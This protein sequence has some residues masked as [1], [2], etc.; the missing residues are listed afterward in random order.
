VLISPWL[1]TR[2]MILPTLA[3]A[4]WILGCDSTTEPTDDDLPAPA[5]FEVEAPDEA[6]AGESFE[7]TLRA[8]DEAGG[9]LE[10]YSGSVTLSPSA[11]RLTTGSVEVQGG[12]GS[13]ATSIEDVLGRVTLAARVGDAGGTSPAIDVVLRE[14]PGDPDDPATASIP[15]L[16]PVPDPA[17]FTLDAPELEGF[18]VSFRTLIVR[19]ATDVTVADLNAD[20]VALGARILGGAPDAGGSSGVLVLGFDSASPEEL[21][22]I[23]DELAGHAWALGL[24]RDTALATKLEPSTSGSPDS[25][26]AWDATPQGGNW[27][28]ELIRAPQMWN[29]N[30][31]VFKTGRRIRVGVIDVGFEPNHPDLTYHT[32]IGSDVYDHGTHVAGTI[33][34]TWNGDGVNGLCPYAD[35][36]AM[37]TIALGSPGGSDVDVNAAFGSMFISLLKLMIGGIP[38]VRVVNMSLGYPRLLD[39]S[40]SWAMQYLANEQG[41][42]LAETLRDQPGLGRA[43][44]VAAA[45]N[46][47]DEGYGDQEARYASPMA[48]AAIAQG[49]DQIIVVESVR[50]T[51]GV[52]GDATRASSSNI[53][54]QVSAPGVD[55]RSTWTGP[56]LYEYSSGTSMATPHVT[57]LAAYALALDPDL[58]HAQLREILTLHALPVAGGASRRIDA[59]RT[60]LEIDRVRGNDRVLELLVDIDDGTSDGNLRVHPVTGDLFDSEDADGD[61]GIG[62]GVVDMSDFR[63]YRDWVHQLAVTDGLSFDG[64]LIHAKHDIDGNGQVETDA[65][66]AVY[67]RGDFNGDGS[68][69]PEATAFVGGNL[70][71]GVTDLA[72]L[73]YAFHDPFYDEEELPAL[74]SSGDVVIDATVLFDMPGVTDVRTEVLRA[75]GTLVEERPLAEGATANV[76]TLALDPGGYD[77]VTSAYDDDENLVAIVDEFANPRLCEDL[78]RKLEIEPYYIVTI[79]AP[80]SAEPGVE[81]VFTARVGIRQPDGT[82]DFPAGTAVSVAADDGTASL[83]SDVTNVDGLVAGRATMLESAT[84]MNLHITASGGALDDET[85]TVAV[86]AG[87][88]LLFRLRGGEVETDVRAEANA[89]TGF[90]EYD[91]ETEPITDFGSL[92]RSASA[93]ISADSVC[94]WGGIASGYGEA[95]SSIEADLT[96]DEATRTLRFTGTGQSAISGNGS[97]DGQ[98]SA[99]GGGA[100]SADYVIEFELGTEDDFDRDAGYRYHVEATMNAAGS[101]LFSRGSG[102]VMLRGEGVNVV[103]GASVNVGDDD[104]SLT[105]SATLDETGILGPGRYTFRVSTTSS[106]GASAP[107][108]PEVSGSGDFTVELTLSPE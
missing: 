64:G 100:A 32:R 17:D 104:G 97:L 53:G 60:V 28:M 106:G 6:S 4:G 70:Q 54:G 41:E 79:Y 87:D 103:A 36:V 58:T 86:S 21:D 3:V 90:Y 73:A 12:V 15:L 10:H 105:D 51:P 7:V 19:V 52:V 18:P 38:D 9:V 78:Y 45:G 20:L 72:V 76:F 34:A 56:K 83:D 40:S 55:I 92:A 101:G 11:G 81:F 30:D 80:E 71:K 63:R 44:I 2:W 88:L 25:T 27:G 49:L 62:D 67:P 29:L 24:A 96:F 1:R 37:D 95:S 57:G 42:L 84:S 77:F 22:G 5:R 16:V 82:V 66:E 102:V 93:S 69:D 13:V 26:W 65:R 48:N 68:L 47:S 33:A 43:F 75:D 31:A 99:G 50:H 107:N 8:L 85:S 23:R 14:L 74:M 91:G 94:F 108:L 98:G 39:T 35:I 61:G 59:F 89:C 46:E